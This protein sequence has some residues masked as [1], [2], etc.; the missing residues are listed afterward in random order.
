[1]RFLVIGRQARQVA[2]PA[3]D[4]VAYWQA[5]WDYIKECKR[6]GTLEAYFWTHMLPDGLASPRV[7][8]GVG[9]LNVESMKQAHDLLCHY[10]GHKLEGGLAFELIPILN[11]QS[12]YHA[13]ANEGF[14][15]LAVGKHT[16]Y[17]PRRVTDKDAFGAVCRTYI[18]ELIDNGTIEYMARTF[19]PEQVD[20]YI[21]LKVESNEALFA[22]LYDYPATTIEEGYQWEFHTLL[23]SDFCFNSML[24]EAKE[25]RN[26]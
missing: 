7:M 2:P 5:C 21:F 13:S 8:K 9:I 3:V 26:L 25:K 20:T 15:F 19:G 22:A 24:E 12:V 6:N 16:L 4:K 11:D 18:Q 17:K 23:D 10:P 14:R 1:M